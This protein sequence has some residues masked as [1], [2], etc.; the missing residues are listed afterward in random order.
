MQGP[1]PHPPLH[2]CLCLCSPAP[3]CRSRGAPAVLSRVGPGRTVRLKTWRRLRHR[4]SEG[5]WTKYRIVLLWHS[6]TVPWQSVGGG[7]WRC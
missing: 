7:G 4:N 2:W 3:G 5:M 6:E 1:I